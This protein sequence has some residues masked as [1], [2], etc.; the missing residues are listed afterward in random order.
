MVATARKLFAH[1][2][3]ADPIDEKLKLKHEFLFSSITSG[4]DIAIPYQNNALLINLFM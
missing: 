1:I 2:N 3:L 4:L